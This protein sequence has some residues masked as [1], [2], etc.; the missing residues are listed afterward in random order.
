MGGSH[1]SC[2]GVLIN[3]MGG[4]RPRLA[5]PASRCPHGDGARGCAQNFCVNGGALGDALADALGGALG[6]ALGGALGGAVD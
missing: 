2:G 3:R 4:L 1:K 6:D 5:L